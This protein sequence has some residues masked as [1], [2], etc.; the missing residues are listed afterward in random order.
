MLIPFLISKIHRATVTGAELNYSGSIAIDPELMKVAGLREFQKVEIYNINNGNRFSTYII[1]GKKGSRD[2]ILNGA[3]AHLVTKGD[4][5]II[6]A[7]AL[8]DERELDSL[9]SVILLMKDN[10]EI[11]EVIT[12]RL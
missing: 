4:K 1:T 10:N 3:A 11:G 2:I 8:I 9:N 12:G 6:A 7:Y 5:L